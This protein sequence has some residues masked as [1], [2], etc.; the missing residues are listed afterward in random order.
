MKYFFNKNKKIVE[1][2]FIPFTT[3][4]GRTENLQF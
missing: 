3:I 1:I 2:K 4:K